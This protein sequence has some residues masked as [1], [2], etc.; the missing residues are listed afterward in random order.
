M[1]P[2]SFVESRLETVGGTLLNCRSSA[3]TVLLWLELRLL[4]ENSTGI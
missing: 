2:D 4:R 3:C 1:S